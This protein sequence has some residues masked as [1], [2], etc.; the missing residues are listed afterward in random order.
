MNQWTLLCIPGNDVRSVVVAPFQR[1]SLYIQPQAGLPLFFA[2]TLDA[3]LFKNRPHIAYEVHGSRGG[4]HSEPQRRH[5]DVEGKKEGR[6]H[7]W[8][9]IGIPG[10]KERPHLVVA[11]CAAK[12]DQFIHPA[13][14]FT[15]VA[16]PVSDLRGAEA[17]RMGDG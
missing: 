3:V 10:I 9:T 4:S 8:S 11:H 17:C 7:E 16:I 5:R 13:T 15:V 14:E 6:A 2:V 1:R 12:D